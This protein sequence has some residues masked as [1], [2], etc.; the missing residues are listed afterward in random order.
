M[1]KHLPHTPV[2]LFAD[3]TA[4]FITGAIYL[5]RPLLS[6]ARVKHGLFELIQEYFDKYEW[7]LN[8]WVILDNHYHLMGR[9]RK[10]EDLPAIFR[11]VHR[12]SGIFIREMT[13][14]EKPVWWNYWDYC[15]RN[16]NDY[17]IRLNYLLNN[18]VKHGVT[19]NLNDYE[20]SSFRGLRDDVGRDRLVRQFRVFPDYKR[21]SLCEKEDDF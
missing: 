2:H 9:S 7:A 19:D 1:P 12:L 16:E 13:N 11:A 17:M 15:P 5:G 20:F 8:H 6:D 18:P 14:C 4:Y 3:N 21:L 10:G